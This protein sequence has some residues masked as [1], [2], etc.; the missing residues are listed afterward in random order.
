MTNTTLAILVTVLLS[1]VA[2]VADYFLKRATE[3][4][5]PYKSGWFLIGLLIYASTAFGTVFVFQ[6]IKLAITGVVYSVSFV[7]FLTALG[8]LYFG[9]ALQTREAVGIVM[10]IT[11]LVLLGRFV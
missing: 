3:I 8:V 1:I 6:H 11:S 7:L 9:E 2:V 10:A 5:V 4:D